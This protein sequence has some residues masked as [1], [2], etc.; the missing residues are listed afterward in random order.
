MVTGGLVVT[1]LAEWTKAL[2][3]VPPAVA[4]LSAVESKEE[5]LVSGASSAW[6]FPSS[7]RLIKGSLAHGEYVRK[8]VKE[9]QRSNMSCEFS[10][11]NYN[12]VDLR[13]RFPGESKL[14]GGAV[15]AT[16]VAQAKGVGDYQLVRALVDS[17]SNRF[18]F[19]SPSVRELKRL[20]LGDSMRKWTA[21]HTVQSVTSHKCVD[22]LFQ[23]GDADSEVA[24]T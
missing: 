6:A 14:D 20:G 4:P 23:F 1:K 13:G 10:C 11:I 16:V 21:R 12:L 17:G 5:K 7:S 15:L 19:I 22:V 9:M 18:T 3:P 24:V 8:M 2:I